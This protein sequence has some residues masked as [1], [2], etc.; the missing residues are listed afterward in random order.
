MLIKSTVFTMVID[1]QTTQ[2]GATWLNAHYKWQNWCKI[3][4]CIIHLHISFG[5]LHIRC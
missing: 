5:Q 4:M 1:G 2:S 3:V